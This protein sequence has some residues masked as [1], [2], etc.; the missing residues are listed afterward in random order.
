MLK[1]FKKNFKT[2][3]DCIILAA[4][5]IIFISLLRLYLVYA[6]DSVDS[7]T[8][9]IWGIVTAIIMLSGFLSAWLYLTK[10]V[11][12]L[13]KKIFIFDKDRV[14]ALGYL[15]MTLSKGVGR[16]IL[17]FNIFNLLSNT[18]LYFST[19]CNA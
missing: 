8:K 11:I 13:S 16:L 7:T 6:V 2:T 3:N 14:K 12:A 17:P 19:V 1:L 18:F 15:T 9:L 10:K 4:P 5:L